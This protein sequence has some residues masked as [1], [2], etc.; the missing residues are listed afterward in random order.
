M[1]KHVKIFSCALAAALAIGCFG[2]CN[3]GGGDSSVDA[4]YE[5][6]KNATRSGWELAAP[7]YMGGTLSHNAYYAGPGMLYNLDDLSV[8]KQQ[9][10][11]NTTRAEFNAYLTKLAAN[12][13][14]LIERNEIGNSVF[15]SYQKNGEIL[16][17]YHAD[18]AQRTQVIIDRAS[19]PEPE[20]E[21]TYTPQEGDTSAIYQ[22]ALMTDPAGQ[23]APDNVSAKLPKGSVERTYTLNGMFYVI[24]LADNRLILV[25]GGTSSQATDK[26]SAELLN[27]L[28][29]VTGANRDAG[30]K[31]R[32]AC[33]LITHA[34][35]DHVEFLKDLATDYTDYVDFERFAFNFPQY[36][37]EDKKLITQMCETFHNN[38]PNALY[39]KVHTGQSLR[40]G[41]AVI[42][43]VTTHEDAVNPNTGYSVANFYNDSSTMF[44]ITMSGKTFFIMGDWGCTAMPAEFEKHLKMFLDIYNVNGAYPFFQS[45]F[46]QLGHHG[47]YHY[48]DYILDY[49]NASVIFVP[50][51]DS[52]WLEYSKTGYFDEEL[53]VTSKMAKRFAENVEVWVESGFTQ[54]YFQSRNTHGFIIDNEGNT[55]YVSEPIRGADEGYLTMIL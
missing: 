30:E 51:A 53:G 28:Y 27:F 32:V 9:T 21:Y 42:D 35:S 33:A 10:I 3:G 8:S 34:H 50:T 31:I 23:L 55:S 14:T 22:Y 29:E 15:L 17:T 1:K 24:K 36:P 18:V 19:I 37:S 13:Y 47:T 40:M 11:T 49:A 20:F 41:N 25:D 43:V 12:D 39:L 4:S 54:I 45:D 44:K 38:Y 16:Y 46:V 7:A 48:Y 26:A 2:G 52:D 6:M 5:A